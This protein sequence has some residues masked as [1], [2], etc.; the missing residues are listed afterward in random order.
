MCM[1]ALRIW[2]AIDPLSLGEEGSY[3]PDR[4]ADVKVELTDDCNCTIC[5]C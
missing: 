5:T 3:V 4:D 1:Y 2:E